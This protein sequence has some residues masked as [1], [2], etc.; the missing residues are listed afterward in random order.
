MFFKTYWILWQNERNLEFIKWKNTSFAR[1][2]ADSKLR[3]KEFLQSK[4]IPV[5]ENFYVIKKHSQLLDLDLSI[6][7]PPFVVKPNFGYWWNWILV[8]DNVDSVG[9]YIT[10]T[11]EIISKRKMMQHFR[12][13]LD[14]FFSLSWNRDQVVIERKVELDESIALIWKYWLPDIRVIVYNMIPIIA[15]LR[16]PTEESGWKA[17]LHVWACWVW[18]EVWTWKLTHITSKN[19]IIKTIPWIGDI[20]WLELPHWDKVLEL[21]SSLQQITWIWY[22]ACDIVLDKEKGPLLLEVNI[23]PWLSVQNANL[24]PLWARLKKVEW[25]TV[26]SV[27]KWVRLA[28]DLFGS[29]LWERIKNITWNILVGPKEFITLYSWE[30]QYKYTAN[31]QIVQNVS[32]IDKNF[33]IEVLKYP[34]EEIEEL[35]SIKLEYKILWQ[36]R[37]TSFKIKE[38]EWVNIILGKNALKGFYIDPFKYKKGQLPQDTELKADNKNAIIRKNYEKQLHKIDAQLADIWK[39]IT[40]IAKLTPT[41]LL[42]EKIKFTASRWEYVPEFKYNEINIDFEGLKKRLKE[43]EIWDIPLSGIFKRKKWE[44]EYKIKFL[45]AF[46]YKNS[47]DITRYSAEL[48]GW[49]R[50]E[51]LNFSQREVAKKWYF[52]EEQE[53]MSFPEMVNF[54]NN[55]NHIYGLELKV[56]EDDIV[57]RMKM[58][59]DTLVVRRGTILWQKE[60]RAVVAHEIEGHYLRRLN[61]R[62][63]LFKIFAQWT[64]YYMTDE[65]WI[66]IYNQNRF[67]SQ[68]DARYYTPFDRYVCINYALNHSYSE[69]IEYL[70]NYYNEDYE[71]IFTFI[72]RVK[73]GLEKVDEPGFFVKDLMYANWYYNIKNFV[74]DEWNL[75]KMYFWKVWLIDLE[76]IEEWDFLFDKAKNNK[77]PIFL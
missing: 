59:G 28:K 72:S 63:K 7:K 29:D 77:I 70:R 5:P 25:I 43:V 57:S 50:D 74:E 23:R 46:A 55:F 35:K 37:E 34:E 39:N 2:L 62:E 49:I 58:K 71:K 3:T 40:I 12:D 19:K 14:W 44:L 75:Q 20:R 10:N 13:I 73:R 18:V 69:L 52:E 32:I 9:N 51:V 65:E 68:K 42:E 41:N 6:L 67:L 61:W 56:I 48:F 33:L 45:E 22:L 64:A 16:V 24:M 60:L 76:E 17:N 53:K 26:T 47:K 31:I 11:W 38:L 15:M 30:K 21:T 54:I 36:K 4:N 27:E 1:Y 8:I 66:A